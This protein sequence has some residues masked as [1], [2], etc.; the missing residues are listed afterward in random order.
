MSQSSGKNLTV[1]KKPNVLN[2]MP[3]KGSKSAAEQSNGNSTAATTDTNSNN[4]QA[5]AAPVDSGVSVSIS[6]NN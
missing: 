5:V 4:N 2:K 6:S 1:T 3:P